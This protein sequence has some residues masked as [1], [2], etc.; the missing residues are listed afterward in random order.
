MRS[1]ARQGDKMLKA[2]LVLPFNVLI[3]IPFIILYFCGFE[4]LEA[5][6]GI[7]FGAMIIL[8]LSGLGLMSWTIF[9]FAHIG[10]GSLAP[11]NPTQKLITTGPYAYVRNPMLTGIFLVLLGEALLFQSMVLFWYLVIFMVI[12]AVYLPLSEEKGLVKRFG[13]EYEVYKRNVPRFI[14]RLRPWKNKK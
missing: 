2:I 3:T 7:V 13:A 10:K 12:N 1:D 4:L 14:P 9:L 8:F 11:W 5:K 6:A